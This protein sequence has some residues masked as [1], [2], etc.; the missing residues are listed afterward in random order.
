[1]QSVGNTQESYGGPEN[2]YRRDNGG[3]APSTGLGGV[4]QEVTPAF[5]RDGKSVAFD[6]WTMNGDAGIASGNGHTLD[7]MDFA[8]GAGG[9]DA[10]G[11]TCGSMAF[12]A[13]RRIYTN[14][15]N[16][17][18]YVGWPAW[19]PD[20]EALVFHNVVT[21]PTSGS[22]LAT[23]NSAQAQLWYTNI[24]PSSGTYPDGGAAPAAAPLKMNALNGLDGT[25][26]SYLPLPADVTGSNANHSLDA[27]YNYEPTINPIAS[28]GYYWVVFTSR[29]MYGNIA[30]LDAF[31]TGNGT[32][33]VAK[34]L[35]VAAID[36]NPA[37]GV[38]PSHP[39]FYLPGQE[40]NAGNMRGFWVVDPCRSNG[41][42]CD[43]GDECCNGFC[44][45]PGDGGGLVCGDK[46]PGCAQELEKC[47]TS[48][49]CCGAGSLTCIN[50]IC[51]KPGPR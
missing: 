31:D 51:S 15:D 18:G 46:P 43:T 50:G 44:R 12:S 25:G 48:A 38:D 23:W 36:I 47:A 26:A 2:I 24:P 1:M 39:A 32:N 7:V 30:K 6:G 21:K 8:C 3:A 9:D 19:T 41:S 28:G 10:G 29:R 20:S 14:S 49:D 27:Q 42:S 4:K 45:A 16:T 13:L 5:S 34:K 35:W 37:P 11:P 40:I 17:N 33:P 22:Q